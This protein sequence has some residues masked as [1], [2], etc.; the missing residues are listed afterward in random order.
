MNHSPLELASEMILLDPQA[1]TTNQ[2]KRL[3]TENIPSAL[4]G[5]PASTSRPK[6]Q[7]LLNR[8]FAE[9][10]ALAARAFAFLNADLGYIQNNWS[11]ILWERSRRNWLAP[12]RALGRETLIPT[13]A[14]QPLVP[15]AFAFLTQAAT[16]ISQVRA[17]ILL[18]CGCEDDHVSCMLPATVVL[19]RPWKTL[20]WVRYWWLLRI[21]YTWP[22]AMRI[23]PTSWTGT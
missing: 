9:M 15:L 10:T 8:R 16:Q 22:C 14:P 12:P 4:P 7:P 20:S 18:G 6:L 21:S 11:G 19:E 5:G 13:K 3:Y 17:C 1:P 23:S 2:L